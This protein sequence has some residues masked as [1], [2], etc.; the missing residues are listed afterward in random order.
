MKLWQDK[1]KKVVPYVP[2]EQ[3]KI[4]N[5]VKLNTNELPYPPSPMAQ[6]AIREFDANNL[7]KYPSITFTELKAALSDVYGVGAEQLFLGNGSDEV[8]A[9]CFQT[10]FNSDKPVLFPDVTYSFY[11]VWCDLYGIPYKRVPLDEGFNIVPSDYFGE[12][13]GIVIANPN[14]PTSIYMRLSSI[15]DILEHNRDVIVVIDEAYIDFGGTSAVS[16]LGKY[17]NLVVVQT[18][19]KSRGLAGMRVGYAMACKELIT[20]LSAVKDS[21]NSYPLDS[22]AQAAAAASARDTEY[23]K[24]CVSKII[25]TRQRLVSELDKLGFETLPSSANFIFTTNKNIS[26]KELFEYLREKGVIVRYFNKPRIDAYLR[27]TVG[28]DM[29]TDRLLEEIKNFILNKKQEDK[30]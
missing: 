4:E 17:D 19:S 16:L 24:E 7:R 28:T 29:E 1:I 22:V 25:N 13:G 2:G 30:A 26:A 3:P 15:E 18:Y 9:L 20:A 12:N 14:A 8:L 5:I 10:F 27:I 11:D 21:F 23:M 6:K